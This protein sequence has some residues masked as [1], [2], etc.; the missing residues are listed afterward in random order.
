MKV[1]WDWDDS[2]EKR[3][4]PQPFTPQDIQM[5]RNAPN[6]PAIIAAKIP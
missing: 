1:R 3:R 5:M 4:E 2:F 6:R